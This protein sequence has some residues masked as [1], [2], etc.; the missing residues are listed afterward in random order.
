VGLLFFIVGATVLVS[1]IRGTQ[2]D[3]F[4]LLAADVPDVAE[5]V[6]AIVLIGM[7]G[8]LP[9]MQTP[10]RALLALVIIVVLLDEQG[11]WAAIQQSLALT[12][13]GQLPSIA[14][15]QAV[16]VVSPPAAPAQSQSSSKS[17]GGGGIGGILSGV[18]KIF[19]FP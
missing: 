4:A 8:Y 17:N 16:A 15:P 3:L 12:Q 7:L 2:N 18:G 6:G 5:Q 13:S 1:A 19:G 11:A 9:G 14:P 10:S